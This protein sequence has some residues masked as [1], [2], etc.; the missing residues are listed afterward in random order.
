MSLRNNRQEFSV[1]DETDEVEVDLEQ[2]QRGHG[3]TGYTAMRRHSNI[4][5]RRGT[6]P[7]PNVD[8]TDDEGDST[9][10]AGPIEE[11]SGEDEEEQQDDGEEEGTVRADDYE[12]SDAGSVESF[13][14]K[15][16]YD[17]EYY[18]RGVF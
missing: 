4:L 1:D 9:E 10:T 3:G 5:R 16:C 17:C 6:Q 8:S 12:P 18:L 13:T 11:Q 2:K 7:L 14:L 15:V